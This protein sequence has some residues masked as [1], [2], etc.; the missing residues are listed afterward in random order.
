MVTAQNNPIVQ[1]TAEDISKEINFIP[2]FSIISIIISTIQLIWRC[3]RPKNEQ[4]A[5]AM[6]SSAYS[7][8]YDRRTIITAKRAV[9]KAARAQGHTL[10][11]AQAQD[12]A[13]KI[14]DN[15]REAPDGSIPDFQLI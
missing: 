2:I 7:N 1:K 8:G 9:L 10:T 3:A 5:K 12:V 13:I 14:L 4:D 6:L 15:F 11:N